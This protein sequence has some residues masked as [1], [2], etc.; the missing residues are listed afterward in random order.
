MLRPQTLNDIIGCDHIKSALTIAIEAS[1]QK[2]D[3][4]P[5]I[6]LC[7]GPGLGKTAIS[8]VIANERG[9]GFKSV[10]SNVFRKRED[11]QNLLAEINDTGYD[12][13]GKIV[14]QIQPSIIFLDEIHQLQKK[15]QECFFQA[16]EDF[17]FTVETKDIYSATTKKDEKWVPK[18]TLIGATTNIGMLDKPFIDRFSLHFTLNLYAPSELL[19]MLVNYCDRAKI[20]C[21]TDALSIIAERSRGIAR[22]AINFLERSRDTAIYLK[23]PVVDIQAIEETFKLLNVDKIGLEDIDI[24]VL[25][26]LY[27][28][29]P[30]KIG[31]E[32]LSSVIGIPEN[33]LK[34][35][36]EPYLLRQGFI[37]PTPSGRIISEAGIKYCEENSLIPTTTTTQIKR[38]F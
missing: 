9:V 15:I 22:R 28:S 32:R 5:H 30:Q 12:S 20:K 34:E 17:K 13:T 23:K 1:K 27:R 21:P 18:F 14:S 11:V 24:Q 19:I 36:V 35:I 7:G 31:A 4:I 29:Y 2:N 25:S 38:R 33:V 26:Y 10:L 8:N 16:M 3:A 6:L 37:Y